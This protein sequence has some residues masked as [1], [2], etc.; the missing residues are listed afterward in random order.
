MKNVNIKTRR[1]HIM[2]ATTYLLVVMLLLTSLLSACGK[3]ASTTTETTTKATQTA[4]PSTPAAEAN[5]WDKFGPPKYG[6]TLNLRAWPSLEQVFFDPYLQSGFGGYS[7]FAICMEN[8]FYTN[9]Y[10]DRDIQP[11]LTTQE[12]NLSLVQGAL[13]D[14]W[15]MP[16]PTTVVAHVR[17]GVYW[18][19]KPPAN[20]PILSLPPLSAK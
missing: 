5:W 4:P 16:D 7:V 2:K 6:G 13:L 19:N 20:G 18:W 11:L 1:H 10:V 8:P 3:T 12:N 17:Q 14:T 15:D 9:W